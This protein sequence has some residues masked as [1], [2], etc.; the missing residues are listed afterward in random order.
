MRGAHAPPGT[1]DVVSRRCQ[2][3]G[4]F[5]KPNFGYEEKKGLWC[6]PHAPP[7]ARDVVSRKCEHAGC[8][9]QP[10]FGREEKKA[11]WCSQHAPEGSF[12]V[13]SKRWMLWCVGQKDGPC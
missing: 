6:R 13:M 11:R 4:C 8:T 1:R 10:H 7:D 9:K 5:K 2:H 12:D 3:P